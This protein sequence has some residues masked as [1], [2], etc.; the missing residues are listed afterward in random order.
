AR[1]LTKIHEEVRRG[2]LEEVSTYYEANPPLGEVT[3]VVSPAAAHGDEEDRVADARA[4]AME[5]LDG[6]MKPSQ[7]A[8]EVSA[9]L[10]LARNAAYRIVHDLSGS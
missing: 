3:V 10:D 7:A 5:L 2:T 9:R 6:G 8:K 4:L 1:E